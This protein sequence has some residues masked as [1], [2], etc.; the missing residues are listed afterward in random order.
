MNQGKH[1][2]SILKADGSTQ[3]VSHWDRAEDALAQFSASLRLAGHPPH[4]AQ[5]NTDR[6]AQEIQR[7]YAYLVMNA[8]FGTGAVEI[9]TVH[10]KGV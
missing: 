7:G 1:T 3:A 4:Q 9:S 6:A 2:V 8:E 10:T 5:F